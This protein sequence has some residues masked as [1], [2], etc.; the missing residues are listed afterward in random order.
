MITLTKVSKIYNPGLPNEVKALDKVDLHIGK[1]ELVSVMGR[2]GSGKTTLLHIL[3]GLDRV[4]YG[5]YIFLNKD[6]AKLNNNQL[7]KLR[8]QSIGIALQDFALIENQSAIS[9]VK[10]PMSFDKTPFRKMNSKAEAALAL[11]G[12]ETLRDRTVKD[13]SGGQKQRV[14][15]ARALVNDP[16]LL[17]A[18]EPTGALD[19][20]TSK[21]ILQ[22]FTSLNKLG[23]T[24][25]IVTHDKDV[26]AYCNRHIEIHDGKIISG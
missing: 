5:E 6:T 13:M 25:I 4:T 23:K 11:V 3:A 16:K 19:S 26:A 20:T 7:S 10:L 24:V 14:A 21:D 22:V 9:N 2:S 1:G 12:I 15:I 18:D 17:L 8:N